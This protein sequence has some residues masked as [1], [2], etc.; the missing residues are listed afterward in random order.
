M[1]VSIFSVFV[2]TIYFPPILGVYPFE[3]P[4][5]LYTGAFL[6]WRLC[7]PCPQMCP[8]LHKHPP[9]SIKRIRAIS[10]LYNITSFGSS[11]IRNNR[12]S[13]LSRLSMCVKPKRHRYAIQQ[14]A[15]LEAMLDASFYFFFLTFHSYGVLCP[16]LT[17]WQSQILYTCRFVSLSPLIT[18]TNHLG[19]TTRPV[20][21]VLPSSQILM[22]RTC[23]KPTRIHLLFFLTLSLHRIL[24]LSI[25]HVVQS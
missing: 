23:S 15:Q 2:P 12:V 22:R 17:T 21:N 3:E 24:Y 18:P 13:Q 10:F 4:W 8:C 25:Y 11:F 14:A 1:F 7:V 9:A 19:V 20:I 6:R 16:L 5:S